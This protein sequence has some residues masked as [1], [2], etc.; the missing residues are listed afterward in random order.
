MFVL[1]QR[2]LSGLQAPLPWNTC[3]N[4]DGTGKNF[5]VSATVEPFSVSH[6]LTW[7]PSGKSATFVFNPLWEA[8]GGNKPRP[9]RPHFERLDQ[10]LKLRSKKDCLDIFWKLKTSGELQILQCLPKPLNSIIFKWNLK[11]CQQW[12]LIRSLSK[13]YGFPPAIVFWFFVKLHPHPQK[14]HHKAH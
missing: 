2:T 3:H 13:L 14:N 6:F 7:K 12:I 8:S 4:V 10:V 11:S 9:F 5:F 1:A